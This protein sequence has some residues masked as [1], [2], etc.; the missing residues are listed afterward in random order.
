MTDCFH[1]EATIL[2][3]LANPSIIRPAV[4]T[5]VGGTVD[6]QADTRC[7]LPLPVV[8]HLRR[9]VV[10]GT[11]LGVIGKRESAFVNRVQYPPFEVRV[12]LP[13]PAVIMG[14]MVPGAL[15][16]EVGSGGDS[17]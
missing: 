7:P 3:R 10:G 8:I 11:V 1:D 12:G 16:G 15:V 13:A 2:K 6:E 4:R 9:H 5:V 14:V 17:V